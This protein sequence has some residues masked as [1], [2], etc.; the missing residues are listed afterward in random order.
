MALKDTSETVASTTGT[1]SNFRR[2]FSPR[3]VRGREL[4]RALGDR[5]PVNLQEQFASAAAFADGEDPGTVGSMDERS[6]RPDREP[7][8]RAGG[9]PQSPGTA[10]SDLNPPAVTAF[11]DGLKLLASSTPTELEPHERRTA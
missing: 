9:D 8:S 11:A 1:L 5:L 4:G 10:G 3:A 7:G 2:P 6:A